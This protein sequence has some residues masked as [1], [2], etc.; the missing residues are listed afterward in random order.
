MVT[1][2]GPDLL[3][4][5]NYVERR[6]AKIGAESQVMGFI[7]TK[8]NF[9]NVIFNGTRSPYNTG[10]IRYTAD[11]YCELSFRDLSEPFNK[12]IPILFRF[13]KTEF[14]AI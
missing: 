9:T 12:P 13:T 4:S 7:A 11:S 8:I 5:A 10:T 2:D 14:L 6:H 1:H 3:N